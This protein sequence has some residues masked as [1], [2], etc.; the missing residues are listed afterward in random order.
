[1]IDF[2]NHLI[3][4]VDDG[5]RDLDEALRAVAAFRQQGVE[6]L[7]CTPHLRASDLVAAQAE[8]GHLAR[9]ETAW[10][11]LR[12]AAVDRFPGTVVHRGVELMLDTIRCD[13]SDPR[14][15]LAGTRFVLVEF[16]FGVIP[17]NVGNVLMRL[18]RA[19]WVPVVAHPERYGNARTD[20][21]D[22]AEWKRS[23]AYLQ[24]NAGSLLG[25][26]GDG[27]AALAWRLVGCGMADFI[28]SD[29]HGR[30]PLHLAAAVAALERHGGGE[31]ARLLTVSNPGR[32]LQGDAPLPV[33]PLL[34]ARSLTDRLRG[35]FGR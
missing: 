21:A 5:A 32:M 35:F 28:A 7:V 30:G 16:P 15:R 34:R 18:A 2:H 24:V 22:A 1:V 23:G 11:S 14:V 9:C 17:P 13:L 10:E 27:P 12:A 19:G 25:R 26:Y 6:T 4:G 33:P 3:P 8:D 29:Y 20:V 31:Q